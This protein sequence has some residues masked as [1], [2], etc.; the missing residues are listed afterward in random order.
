[1]SLTVRLL[2]LALYCAQQELDARRNGK[3]PGVL[4]WNA[5][6]VHALELEV[7]AMSDPGHGSV[8]TGT[9]LT[10]DVHLSAREVAEV[11]GCTDRQVRRIANDLDGEF[12]DGRWIFP[13]A[14]VREYVE[15]LTHDRNT[16]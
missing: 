12:V 15:A 10:H 5:E 9:E 7:V 14:A 2:S 11:L 6:L 16:A 1:V 13:Q 4:P 3:V 8:C